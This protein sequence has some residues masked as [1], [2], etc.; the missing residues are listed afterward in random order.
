MHQ[1]DNVGFT[2]LDRAISNHSY[3]AIEYL[4]KDDPSQIPP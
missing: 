4:M 3:E 2:P 1:R